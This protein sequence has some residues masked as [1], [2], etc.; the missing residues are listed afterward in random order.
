MLAPPAQGAV[1]APVGI[2]SVEQGV[3]KPQAATQAAPP[4]AVP[5]SQAALIPAV[6]EMLHPDDPFSQP[7]QK[8]LA[9][10]AAASVWGEAPPAKSAAP[11]WKA[12]DFG[13]TP[14]A[15]TIG[16]TAWEAGERRP[17]LFA[18]LMARFRPARPEGSPLDL[19]GMSPG[20]R[21]MMILVALG[22]I[23][24]IV[25]VLF[26]LLVWSGIQLKS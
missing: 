14:A 16:M 25:W 23:V 17:G 11:S 12:E 8:A 4:I 20:V 19:G 24:L 18:R 22:V 26:F 2:R 1:V 15:E 5:T 13:V 6:A 7:L 3:A 21:T 10:P 9:T